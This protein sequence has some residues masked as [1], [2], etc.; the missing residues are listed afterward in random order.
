MLRVAIARAQIRPCFQDFVE[1]S[2][3]HPSVATQELVHGIDSVNWIAHGCDD[4]AARNVGLDKLA[5]AGFEKRAGTYL[6]DFS[7]TGRV[8]KVIRVPT[9]FLLVEVVE[10]VRILGPVGHVHGV[11]Q[12]VV[13][14][15]RAGTR[16][17]DS[18]NVGEPHKGIFHTNWACS[19]SAYRR[20]TARSSVD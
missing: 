1:G 11:T 18:D 16:G 20:A 5:G 3:A 15:G 13:K 4:F 8:A 7:F 9:D 19:A 14:P 10:E 12:R 17:P 2:A 6:H